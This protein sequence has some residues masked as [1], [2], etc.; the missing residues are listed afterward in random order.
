MDQISAVDGYILYL[1][2]EGIQI[3]HFLYLEEHSSWQEDLDE[4]MFLTL[5]E[6]LVL[7]SGDRLKIRLVNGL[8]LIEPV[9]RSGR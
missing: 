5:I 8:E 6:R 7:L 9:E 2:D 1:N 4:D 3:A